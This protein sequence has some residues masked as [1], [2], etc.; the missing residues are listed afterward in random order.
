MLTDVGQGYVVV[1]VTRV[2]LRRNSCKGR[3]WLKFRRRDYHDLNEASGWLSEMTSCLSSQSGAS[4][5]TW[6]IWSDRQTPY[7]PMPTTSSCFGTTF[8]NANWT[9]GTSDSVSWLGSSPGSVAETV[10]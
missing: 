7:A 5:S 9:G 8:R 10:G 1:C 6:T 4:S 3:R 2:L